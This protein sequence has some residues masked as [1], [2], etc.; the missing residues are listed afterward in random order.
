MAPNEIPAYLFGI[1][2]SGQNI[3]N[4]TSISG[5][6]ITFDAFEYHEGGMNTFVHRLPGA[7][8]H[9]NLVLSRPITKDAGLLKWVNQ[10]QQAAQTSDVSITM[11]DTSG[12]PLQKWVFGDAFPIRWT[13]PAVEQGGYIAV[14]TVEITHSGLK[15]S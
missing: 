6:E 1:E 8:R 3:P 13:G 11:Y 9:P 15:D 14:E 10:T 4:F 7:V 2:A 12:S 5:L